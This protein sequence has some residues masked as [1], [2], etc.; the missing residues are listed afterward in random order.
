[1]LGRTVRDPLG[2][3]GGGEAP[4]L[5]LLDLVHELPPAKTTR[6]VQ[7]TDGETGVELDGYEIHHGATIAGPG[8]RC[9]R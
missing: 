9:R 6:H 1:M 4:G 3:E 7:V 5:G 2:I 8:A